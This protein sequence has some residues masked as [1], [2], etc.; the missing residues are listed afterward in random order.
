MAPTPN[1]AMYRCASGG[2]ARDMQ[3][4][5]KQKAERTR[6]KG[7]RKRYAEQSNNI[8]LRQPRNALRIIPPSLFLANVRSCINKVDEIHTILTKG[9]ADIYVLTETW[10]HEE[11]DDSVIYHSDYT[12]IRR[13]RGREGGG[14]AIFIKNCI[15]NIIICK[16]TRDDL[17]ILSI[18]LANS[19]T[20]LIALYHPHWGVTSI[21]EE[22]CD[23]INELIDNF[24]ATHNTSISNINLIILG[25]FNDLRHHFSDLLNEYGL[26][27]VIN[28]PTRGINTLDCICSNHPE[29]YDAPVQLPP[30]GRSDHCSIFWKNIHRKQ[31]VKIKKTI[32]KVTPAK[33]VVFHTLMHQTDWNDI[34][35]DDNLADVATQNLQS[36]ILNL[37][38]AAFP[39]KTISISSF[40]K[41]WMTD[42]IKSLIDQRDRAYSQNK[43]LKYVRLKEAVISAILKAKQ[44][45]TR[46]CISL[47][48]HGIWKVIGSL[49]NK[50]GI[51]TS[52]HTDPDSIND[53]FLA[54]QLPQSKYS[55]FPESMNSET[56]WKSKPI[57]VTPEEVV[58][59]LLK[60]K[61]K[62][63]GPDSYPHWILTEYADV[64]SKPVATVFNKCLSEGVM[65]SCFKA[66]TIIPIPKPGSTPTEY[67]PISL[68]PHV[69][70]VL[71][72]IVID[73][74]IRPEILP[75]INPN[76]FA[77]TG[78]I[79][80]GT[81]NA[82][83][84]INIAV[85]KHLDS[86]SG[87]S[88]ILLIDFAKAFDRAQRHRIINCLIEKGAPKEC[89]HWINSFLSNRTQRVF[90]N[91]KLSKWQNVVSG[92]PQ[93]SLLGPVLF[94]IL[95]D[96]LQPV[97]DQ[98]IYI[99]YADDITVVHN[100]R[101]NNDDQ[102]QQEWAHICC[103][104]N[105]NELP[106]N[107]KKT[108]VLDIIT[109]KELNST[110]DY[111]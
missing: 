37:F 21:H 98:S 70:K 20:L 103:W 84:S 72:G 99:K 52:T 97:L 104:A 93:G 42:E 69:S 27:Q 14:I 100:V 22:T 95:M 94:S 43:A 2:Q 67:R 25:D 76:Q 61:N 107:F 11:I 89:I 58:K 90:V 5:V 35:N 82:L 106:I 7:L 59:R 54:T 12:L 74:W 50:K 38:T 68:L 81:T 44:T 45:F 96:S 85:L 46:K 6:Q 56:T 8:T 29:L 66:A 19:K 1:V 15:K 110:P 80:G 3:Q 63:A 108:Q 49:S 4:Q 62:S 64:L 83:I 60:V 34:N 87:G 10:L 24:L 109:K 101:T 86:S 18:Y 91:A 28:F 26:T 71:E 47:N 40:D 57:Q 75:S 79:G 73:H 32:H 23:C 13:D 39:P 48:R 30:I 31:P 88:R 102:L 105:E 16:G 33:K 111:M 17:E 9:S 55:D 78:N 36:K 77:F 53:A 92:V 65:P 41:P 51:T